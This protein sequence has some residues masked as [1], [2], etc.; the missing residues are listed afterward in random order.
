MANISQE[1]DERYYVYMVRCEDGSLY[2]GITTDVVRRMREHLSGGPLGARY[3]RTHRPEGLAAVWETV[4]RVAASR[5]EYRIKRLPAVQK[6]V[7]ASRP[8]EV[9]GI[10]GLQEGDRYAPCDPCELARLWGEA[11]AAAEQREA[12]D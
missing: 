8:E 12:M 2:T 10:G 4:G 11:I 7:L 5:L 6:L 3:T 1:K 9:D